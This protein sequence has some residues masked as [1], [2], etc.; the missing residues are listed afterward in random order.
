MAFNFLFRLNIK[1]GVKEVF[2][3]TYGVPSKA[4]DTYKRP[5][6]VFERGL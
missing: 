2:I 4:K 3:D 6:E 5:L 1:E